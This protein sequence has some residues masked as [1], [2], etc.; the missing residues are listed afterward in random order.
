M[1]LVITEKGI[2]TA[3]DRLERCKRKEEVEE[4]RVCIMKEMS[5]PEQPDADN[6]T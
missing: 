5:T 2:T 4:E 6:E 1:C 3:E